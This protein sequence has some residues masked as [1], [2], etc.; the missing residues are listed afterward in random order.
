[1]Y[2]LHGEVSTLYRSAHSKSQTHSSM[3]RG[4]LAVASWSSVLFIHCVFGSLSFSDLEAV[5]RSHFMVA[6]HVGF[7]AL[8]SGWLCSWKSERNEQVGHEDQR[9][10]RPCKCRVLVDTHSAAFDCPSSESR[11]KASTETIRRVVVASLARGGGEEPELH[12]GAQL[13]TTVRHQ[14]ATDRGMHGDLLYSISVLV[15]FVHCDTIPV[16]AW[17]ILSEKDMRPIIASSTFWMAKRQTC[18]R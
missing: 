18:G 1:M 7:P 16:T 10:A 2:S 15:R 12:Y 9:E 8:R 17:R 13:I 5:N 3:V 4:S 6:R 14:V 11:R